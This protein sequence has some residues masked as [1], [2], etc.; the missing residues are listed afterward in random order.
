[1]K[2]CRPAL[3]R[4]DA[5]M[6][7]DGCIQLLPAAPRLASHTVLPLVVPA[8]LGMQRSAVAI[9]GGTA[10][11]QGVAHLTAHTRRVVRC[12]ASALPLPPPPPQ[13]AGTRPG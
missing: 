3:M 12:G 11:L 6:R 5:I 10:V 4:C 9:S 7:C 13:Q 1:M 8:V 2:A